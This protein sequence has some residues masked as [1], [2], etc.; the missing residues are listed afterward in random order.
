VVKLP[1]DVKLLV[2]FPD[3][4]EEDGGDIVVFPGRNIAEAL[5]EGFASRG[6]KVDNPEHAGEHGWELDVHL[7]KRRFWIQVTRID[8]DDCLLQTDNKTWRIGLDEQAT[9]SFL[10]DLKAIL[11]SDARFS[12]LEWLSGNWRLS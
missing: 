3:D 9:Q 8:E 5:G 7:N 10:Q 2:D 12:Q 4:T 11:E 1:A 6:Y